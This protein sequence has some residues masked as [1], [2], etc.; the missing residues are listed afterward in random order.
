MVQPALSPDSKYA[1]QFATV[2]NDTSN[3]IALLLVTDLDT[4]T[5]SSSAMPPATH[6][7]S[8]G[9]IYGYNM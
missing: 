3:A 1:F 7:A 8:L 2:S 6:A 9:S 5:V 4:G